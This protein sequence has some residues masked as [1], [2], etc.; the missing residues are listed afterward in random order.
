MIQTEGLEGVDETGE[1]TLTGQLLLQPGSGQPV[2][3][4]GII[5]SA[6]AAEVNHVLHAA[7]HRLLHGQSIPQGL[8]DRVPGIL[9][10]DGLD[11]LPLE[12]VG[13][14]VSS[15]SQI[16]D[17]L[18]GVGPLLVCVGPEESSNAGQV[19]RIL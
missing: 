5:F 7:G 17:K 18:L 1:V 3:C 9:L 15:H 16:T 6:L 19:V 12:E 11:G 10:E 13:L 4:V 2:S 14:L 8:A